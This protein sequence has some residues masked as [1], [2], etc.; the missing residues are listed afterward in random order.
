MARRR[1][2]GAVAHGL[3][4]RGDRRP[5]GGGS[6]RQ[7]A[8]RPRRHPA[9]PRSPASPTRSTR[10]LDDLHRRPG[11]RQHLRQADRHRRRRRVLRRARHVVEPGRRRRPG[12]STSCRRRT[13][14]NGE[15]F[16]PGR[17]RVHLRAHPR[18]GDGERLRRRCSTSIDSVDATGAAPGDVPAE[19]SR[20]GRSSPTS[21]TTARS[22]TRRRSSAATRRATRSA[23]GR[24]SSSSG[25][26]ATTSRWRRTPTTS[27]PASRSST[28]SSSA[29]C[30][31]TRAASTRCAA[32]ELDWVDAVPL[33]QLP[34]LSS[35][36]SVHLRHQRRP[37]ASRTS[38]RSTRRRR[39]STSRRCARPSPGRSTAP[40]IRDVAY[41]GAGE[42]GV[43][44][45]CRRVAVVRRRR[46]LRRR[47]RRRQGQA[48]A[49]RRRHH[50]HA[51]DRATSACRST[52]SC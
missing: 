4:R 24:S 50:R 12:C 28:P 30:S 39:R 8:D 26:R 22:S 41:F 32:G 2:P 23:P 10:R 7:D 9:R 21:P 51:D 17:R 16:T 48:A 27:S 15:P 44:R 31:S 3:R 1:P 36:D 49:G 34:T 35:D 14:H 6:P 43:A 46:R 37:P 42:P 29:S 45:R 38:W 11:L 33:Q 47:S 40:Q 13:F 20:S 19:V 52:R 18:P 5:A 25:C